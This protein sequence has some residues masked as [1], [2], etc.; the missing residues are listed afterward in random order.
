M[1]LALRLMSF[2]FAFPMCLIIPA[3]LLNIVIRTISL[4]QRNHI[5]QKRLNALRAETRRLSS[6][7]NNPK[8]RCQ[9]RRLQA[10][11]SEIGNVLPL[12]E[13]DVSTSSSLSNSDSID[14]NSLLAHAY[15]YNNNDNCNRIDDDCSSDKNSEDLNRKKYWLFS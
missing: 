11:H 1:N 12:T 8:N 14:E 13:Q 2:Q 9:E 4:V 6:T 7:L 5:L 15:I 10:S 3:D